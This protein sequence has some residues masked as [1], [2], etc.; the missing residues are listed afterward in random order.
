MIDSY[1]GLRRS[2]LERH[3]GTL[4]EYRS[5]LESEVS[6]GFVTRENA[7]LMLVAY[8]CDLNNSIQDI[9]EPNVNEGV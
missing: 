4:A 8:I 6:S 5:K 3:Y 7:D 9:S 2:E 1:Y